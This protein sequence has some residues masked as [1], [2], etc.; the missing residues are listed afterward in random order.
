MHYF[1]LALSFFFLANHRCGVIPNLFIS[2]SQV[3]FVKLVDRAA[4]DFPVTNVYRLE[5]VVI[6]SRNSDTCYC[7]WR[8]LLDYAS[9]VWT[10]IAFL[11]LINIKTGKFMYKT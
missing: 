2:M 10:K 3:P 7:C 9:K 1:D 4:I 11:R 5:E 8:P 6:Y